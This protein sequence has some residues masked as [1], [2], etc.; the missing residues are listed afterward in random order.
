MNNQPPYWQICKLSPNNDIF[1]LMYQDWDNGFVHIGNISM[2]DKQLSLFP[3]LSTDI[4]EDDSINRFLDSLNWN[5]S[6]I[7]D[8]KEHR[9]LILEFHVANTCINSDYVRVYYIDKNKEFQHESWEI[10]KYDDHVEIINPFAQSSGEIK[11][12]H[13]QDYSTL[14]ITNWLISDIESVCGKE[15]CIWIDFGNR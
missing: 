7:N 8:T 3:N 11:R 4:T 6:P 10:C 9:K 13:I 14:E 15:Y 12:F 1:K 5:V 2:Y